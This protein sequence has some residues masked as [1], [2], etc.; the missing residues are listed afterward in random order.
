VSDRTEHVFEMEADLINA[1]E[2]NQAESAIDPYGGLDNTVFFKNED[3]SPIP[4]HRLNEF[5]KEHYGKGY[6]E[7][8]D[9]IIDIIKVDPN[10]F[11]NDELL[12]QAIPEDLPEKTEQASESW[13]KGPFNIMHTFRDWLNNVN[14]VV[15]PLN[16]GFDSMYAGTI[17]KEISISDRTADNSGVK[18]KIFVRWD[19]ICQILN[20]LVTPE[21]KKDHALIELTY[22]NPHAPIYKPGKNEN[23]VQKDKSYKFNGHSSNH[24]LQYAVPD[25]KDIFKSDSNRT[26][27]TTPN[28]TTQQ[29][30]Q[31]QYNEIPFSGNI[32]SAP[33]TIMFPNSD[34][35]PPILGRSFDTNICIMP[36]QL[37]QMKAYD[38]SLAEGG[39]IKQLTSFINTQTSLT[40]I[41]LIYFNLDH[42]ISTYEN[43]I[44]EEYKTTNSLGEERT[45]RRLKKEFSFH[46][47]ITTIWND[48]NGACGGF[49]DFGLHVE[50]SRPNVARIIDFTFK[51]KPSDISEDRPLYKFVPQGL[52]SI[53]RESNFQSKIDNDFASVISI[54]AQAP[55]DIHSLEAMSFK[56]FH[57]N[58]K[59]RFTSTSKSEV[60]K[61]EG[62]GQEQKHMMYI[63]KI[64]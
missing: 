52:K 18:K 56:A 46:A 12:Y 16:T 10:Y 47:F 7:I 33:T 9:L 32:S 26:F 25:S 49:Y 20:K 28:D 44:L 61:W 27:L 42:L 58:I 31:G 64:Y 8:I 30:A 45:K 55:N 50:H 51:G 53:A 48:V 23:G 62:D 34:H 14:N 63:N 1:I 36:H 21:Y 13:L 41:G 19:L 3:G 40:D 57:K 60:G 39:Q 22:L 4:I 38:N 35:V 6:N 17:L 43:L 24:Y 54:A 15:P 37:S 5:N 2:Q 29:T 59:N 11:K